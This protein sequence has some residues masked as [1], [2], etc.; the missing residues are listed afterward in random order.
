MKYFSF[1][2]SRAQQIGLSLNVI[3]GESIEH[4]SARYEQNLAVW[5]IL[6]RNMY[7]SLPFR[8]Y[9]AFNVSLIEAFPTTIMMLF[10]YTGQGPDFWHTFLRV[11]KKIR[12]LN[13]GAKFVWNGSHTYCIEI[14]VF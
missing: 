11:P 7:L 2:W 14:M 1:F 6:Y 3:L 12:M 5:L 9:V 13:S 8:G 10:K 4:F